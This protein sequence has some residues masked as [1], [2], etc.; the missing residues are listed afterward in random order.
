VSVDLAILVSCDLRVETGDQESSS[1]SMG[2]NPPIS[3]LPLG[4]LE[5][6]KYFLSF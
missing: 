2:S 6:E 3:G 5:V 1:V 4:I